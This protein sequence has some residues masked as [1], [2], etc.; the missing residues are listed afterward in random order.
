MEPPL[1]DVPAAAGEE[2][3]YEHNNV[4][5]R[6]YTEHEV[7]KLDYINCAGGGNLRHQYM[8]ALT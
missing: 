7:Y 6:P 1:G 8:Y 3:L 2:I 4:V 5:G